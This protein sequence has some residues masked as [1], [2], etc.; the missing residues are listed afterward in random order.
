MHPIRA[1]V[2]RFVGP[3][4]YAG[5]F[6]FQWNAHRRTQLDSFS[7]LPISR[8]RLFAVSGWPQSL[9]GALILEAGS[10]AGR[11]T[12][13]L[14]G[15]GGTVFSFDFSSAVDANFLNHGAAPNV[16]LSQSDILH[17]PFAP[18]TF[19]KVMCLGVLQHTP[20][21]EA[22]FKS[23]VRQVKPGGEL[24]ID[25]YTRRLVSLLQWKYRLRPL[26][27]RMD[28]ATLYRCIA[29]TTPALVPVARLLR[30]L[31]GRA[32]ARLVPIVE[33][34]HLG[35]PPELNREW[36]VLDTFDMYAP[37]HDHPQSRA[38]VA[39]WFRDA[40]FESVVVDYGPNGVVGRGTRPMLRPTTKA[41]RCA[42]S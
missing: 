5:S 25:V 36:A 20:Q 33:Y 40:G 30:R 28:P 23:L 2:P 34:S 6:G 39:R 27:R 35:L 29:R 9:H 37:A 12:E 15:T 16:H 31:L 11:F 42:A 3:D 7:G 1:G 38:T 13:V 26:T 4:N 22:S 32:G 14:A 8:E 18:G 41:Q 21:P 19:D 24:G 10:G 17:M